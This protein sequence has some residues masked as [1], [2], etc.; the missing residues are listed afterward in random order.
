VKQ[1]ETQAAFLFHVK[2]TKKQLSLVSRETER[3]RAWNQVVPVSRE[4]ERNSGRLLVSRETDE[5][6]AFSCF[7]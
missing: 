5:K 3:N 7:T 2:Q 6:A 4:T 1:S